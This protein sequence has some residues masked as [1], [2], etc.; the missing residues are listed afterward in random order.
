MEHRKPRLLFGLTAF[1]AIGGVSGCAKPVPPPPTPQMQQT[2]ALDAAVY[3]INHS[4][5]LTPADKQRLTD[6]V[7]AAPPPASH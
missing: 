1:L 5:N 3:Q 4:P 7:R 2:T 6:Q